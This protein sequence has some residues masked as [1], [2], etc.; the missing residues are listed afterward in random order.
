MQTL[1]SPST[2]PVQDHA[3]QALGRILSLF[4]LLSRHPEGDTL[5]GVSNK[6]DL[7]KSSLF[8]ILRHLTGR[9]YLIVGTDR[10]YRLGPAAYELAMAMLSTME[11]SVIARPHMEA[12][13]ERSG[14]TVLIGN[15]AVDGPVAVY[16]DTVESSNP[17]RYIVKIGERRELYCSAVGKLVL[18]YMS[19]A[20][21]EAYLKKA[22]LRRI[23]PNTITDRNTLRKEAL[24]ARRRGLAATVQEGVS[25]ASALGAPILDRTGQF[26]AA[27]VLAGPSGR[28]Q[29]NKVR[30]ARSV[31]ES[32][33]SVSRALGY[34]GHEPPPP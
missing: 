18:A 34:K 15:L 31:R 21:R 29:Q 10:R 5:T 7:P 30:F 19:D 9:D 1:T 22:D 17:V 3:P 6:L 25:G 4:H 33:A 24:E 27:L 13:A 32:A 28:I 12:L 20:E 26:V 14:E 2:A 11:L 8:N 16:T 23:T